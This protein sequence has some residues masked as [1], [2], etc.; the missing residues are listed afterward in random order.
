MNSMLNI[1]TAVMKDLPAQYLDVT[2]D[3]ADTE[4]L[5][6]AI[7]K[8]FIF[9]TIWGACSTVDAHTC[10]KF[11]QY[12]T[13]VFN[14]NDMPRGSIFDSFVSFKPKEPDWEK[15]EAIQP[16]FDFSADKHFHE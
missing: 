14:V 3:N 8:A 4:Y 5:D 11:E 1:F 10:T 15:W 7:G 9:A 6:K 13:N 16:D 2:S 12:I